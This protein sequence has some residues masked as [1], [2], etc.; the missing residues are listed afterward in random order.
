MVAQKLVR[1]WTFYNGY[2]LIIDKPTERGYIKPNFKP[3][4]R[5]AINIAY[6]FL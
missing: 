6:T 2:T 5:H 4:P 3:I 1:N